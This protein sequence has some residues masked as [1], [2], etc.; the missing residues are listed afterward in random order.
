MDRRASYDDARGMGE[1]IL[2]NRDTQHRYWLLMEI[3][4][5]ST[6][7]DIYEDGLSS[8]VSLPTHLANIMSRA[9]TYP[10]IQFVCSASLSQG[11]LK[12][13][14][15]GLQSPLSDDVHLFN[16]RT[17]SGKESALMI[18]HRQGFD[19][20]YWHLLSNSLQSLPPFDS[21]EIKISSLQRTSLTGNKALD[22]KNQTLQD[23]NNNWTQEP[24]RLQT[25]KLHF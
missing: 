19:C 2:D 16:L 9:L 15:Q 8:A 20:Q 3:K 7:D 22:I 5:T 11:L 21:A 1:G 10:P 14:V 13:Q 17:T 18:L 23:L 6:T 4:S 25:F 24:M 12:S